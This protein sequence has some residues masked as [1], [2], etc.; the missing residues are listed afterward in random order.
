[1]QKDLV[2]VIIVNWNGLAYLKVCL[3]AL[4]RQTYKKIEVIFVDNNSKDGSVEYVKKVFPKVKIILNKDNFG[5]A[6]G[7]NVGYKYAKGEYILF[8]NNDTKIMPDAINEFVKNLSKRPDVGGAQ[9]KILLMDEPT[10]LDSVGAFLTHTGILN[11]YG[12]NKKDS[13]KYNKKIYLYSAKGAF[14]IFKKKA[15]EAI[16][17]NGEILDSTY[18]CYFEETDMCHRVWLAGYKI[19][20]IPSALMYHKLG[21]T[22]SR[23]NN[24]F[25]QYHSIKNRVSSYIKNLNGFNL[26]LILP[27]H[28]VMVELFG[29]RAIVQSN[30]QLFLAI[31]KAFLWDIA[32]IKDILRKRHIVQGRIRKI[33]DKLLFKYAINE[34][35]ID[36]YLDMPRGLKKYVDKANVKE[37]E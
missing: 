34:V 35:G 23:L 18:F 15:L 3:S 2:S 19:I 37:Y 25:V 7:N 27:I 20:Y 13:P 8:L 17:V 5:F 1:M 16:K 6:E 29:L 10:K 12:A 14:M 9:G 26:L 33:S 22:S 31:Q 28:V 32:N 30:W 21:G 36:Y 24:S 11:H 4:S